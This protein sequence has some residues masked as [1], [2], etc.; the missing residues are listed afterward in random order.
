MHNQQTASESSPCPGSIDVNCGFQVE[1]DLGA[2]SDEL[3]EGSLNMV[4]HCQTQSFE[5][6]N[7]LSS[8][9]YGDLL[10]QPAETLTDAD[11]DFILDPSSEQLRLPK[12][13]DLFLYSDLIGCRT[14][15]VRLLPLRRI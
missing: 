5:A 10:V 4:V 11:N 2:Y 6:S 7:E 8:P 14:K 1:G 13:D 12:A 3:P 15:H 9:F